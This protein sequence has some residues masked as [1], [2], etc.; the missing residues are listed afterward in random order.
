MSAAAA[1]MGFP[2]Q[3]VAS[4]MRQLTGFQ[5]VATPPRQVRKPNELWQGFILSPQFLSTL[6]A[7]VARPAYYVQCTAAGVS[8]A[9]LIGASDE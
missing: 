7:I 6:S 8:F 9:F 5:I 2:M 3:K 4:L 1:F